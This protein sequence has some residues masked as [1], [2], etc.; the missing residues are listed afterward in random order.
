MDKKIPP[1]CAI[2][3]R[4]PNIRMLERNSVEMAFISKY[5]LVWV[6]MLPYQH[7]EGGMVI[8]ITFNS[9][10]CYLALFL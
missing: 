4:S 7:L 8:F 5:K 1:S 9:R 6:E 2:W 3:L 10:P